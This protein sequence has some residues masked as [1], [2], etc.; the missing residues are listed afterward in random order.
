MVVVIHH[1][2]GLDPTP[3]RHLLTAVT[4]LVGATSAPTADRNTYRQRAV[5]WCG[6]LH[7]VRH[8]ED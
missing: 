7:L 6:F 2:L 4:F 1:S 8:W 3:S 5:N